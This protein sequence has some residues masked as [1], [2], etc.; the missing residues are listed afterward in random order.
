LA[1]GFVAAADKRARF[2]GGSL[3]AGCF[4]AVA[5][6]LLAICAATRAARGASQRLDAGL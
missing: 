6:P 5:L 1:V 3:A 2:A 4:A